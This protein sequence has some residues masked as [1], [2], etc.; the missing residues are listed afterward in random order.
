MMKRSSSA[1]A[2]VVLTLLVAGA[3]LTPRPA[4]ARCKKDCKQVLAG[5]AKACRQLCAKGKSGRS[6]R[7][8]CAMDLKAAKTTCRKATNPTPPACG[9]STTTTT[10]ASSP[11]GIVVAGSLAAGPGRFNYNAALGLPGANAACNTNF[12]GSHVCSLTELQSAPTSDLAGLRDT[13]GNP[14]TSFW[15]IDPNAAPLQQCNDDVGGGSGLNW[16]YG[17]AHTVSRGERV[18][19]TNATGA[20]GSVQMGVQCN[21]AGNSAVACCH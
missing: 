12:P 6:C 16:E 20:L 14:V 1:V 4:Q 15:A 13:G 3:S 17:T 9:Q 19:L 21:I 7:T 18:S 11:T 8:A 2:Y 10:I 5:A